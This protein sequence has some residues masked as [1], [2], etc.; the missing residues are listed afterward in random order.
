MERKRFYVVCRGFH[1]GLFD[2]WWKCENE[3]IGYRH[4]KYKGFA[5][6]EDAIIYILD[7]M[8]LGNYILSVG[9]L[10]QTFDRFDHF[11]DAI[12]NL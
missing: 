12:E 2:A 10:F 11:L 5:K 6:L 4:A 7:E 1:K 3:V 8:D 9:G